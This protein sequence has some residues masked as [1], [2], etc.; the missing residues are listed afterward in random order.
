MTFMYLYLGLFLLEL[1]LRPSQDL[2]SNNSFRLSHHRKQYLQ[3]KKNL[4]GNDLR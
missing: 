2:L 4:S 1:L 3:K